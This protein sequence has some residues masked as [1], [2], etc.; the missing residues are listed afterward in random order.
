LL[1]FSLAACSDDDGGSSDDEAAVRSAI[2]GQIAAEA[3]GDANA[4]LPHVTDN[5]LKT[6]VGGTRDDV[7]ADPSLFQSDDAPQIND[8]SVSGNK[9][10]AKISFNDPASRLVYG[11]EV[12]LVKEDGAWKSDV[13]HVVSASDVP[14]S[15]KKV[16]VGLKEFA[17]DFSANQITSKD[18][19]VFHVENKG[20]QSHMMV[21]SKI[22]ADANLQQLLQAEDTPPGVE[23]VGGAFL[24]SPGDEADVVLKDKLAPGR[25]VMLCFVGD[26]DDPEHVPHVA[27]GMVSDF[28]V[29]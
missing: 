9:A 7:K 3:S 22:P 18:N 17:F 8:I 27:K 6:V 16:N 20:K 25:Y 1:A 24:F 14:S 4:Y 28:T 2:D 13:L 10:T 11:N 29:N 12:D 23:D 21:I 5:W 19:L 26:E 15:S